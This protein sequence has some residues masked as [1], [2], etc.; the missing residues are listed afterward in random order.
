MLQSKGQRRS[1][2]EVIGWINAIEVIPEDFRIRDAEGFRGIDIINAGPIALP[3]ERVAGAGFLQCGI[4]VQRRPDIDEML[5]PSLDRRMEGLIRLRVQISHQDER[6]RCTRGF[7]PFKDQLRSFLAGQWRL[8]IEVGVEDMDGPL[9]ATIIKLR[10]RADAHHLVAPGSRSHDFRGI[11]KP[12]GA[13][14][15]HR[16]T[17]RLH[18]QR[19]V[20]SLG[21]SILPATAD[22][23]VSGGSR[24]EIIQHGTEAFLDA[25]DVRVVLRHQGS[26]LIAPSSPCP[27]PRVSRVDVAE[28]EREHAQGSWLGRPV[29]QSGEESGSEQQRSGEHTTRCEIPAESSTVLRL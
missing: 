6:I 28:V 27:I 25:N 24:R 23:N 10:P 26:D 16:E 2:R 17:I 15:L 13:G 4:G 9:V 29:E 7:H 11:G 1:H 3:I 22:L 12:E 18:Q 5:R 14:L 19:G 8:V 20:F 21:Q